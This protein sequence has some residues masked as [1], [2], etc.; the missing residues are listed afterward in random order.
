MAAINAALASKLD[1]L[2]TRIEAAVATNIEELEIKFQNV[3]NEVK[4]LKDHVD[5]GMNHVENVLKFDIDCVGPCGKNEQYSRKNN[6]QVICLEEEDRANLEEKFITFFHG[7]LEED[8]T[9]EEIDIIHRTGPKK[10][11]GGGHQGL[12]CEGKL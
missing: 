5:D 8:I 2:A 3:Q 9:S 6:L 4:K 1:H 7:H 10:G 12:P 11:G